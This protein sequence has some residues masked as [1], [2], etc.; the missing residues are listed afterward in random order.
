MEDKIDYICF[1]GFLFLMI[2]PLII[3]AIFGIYIELNNL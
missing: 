2:L 1:F 3:C